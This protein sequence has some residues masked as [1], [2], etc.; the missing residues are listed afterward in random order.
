M[1]EINPLTK[2]EVMED[3]FIGMLI[4]NDNKIDWA[5]ARTTQEQIVDEA[6]AALGELTSDVID[7]VGVL[8]DVKATKWWQFSEPNGFV[9]RL[10]ISKPSK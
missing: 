8:N 4:C 1:L 3:I 6:I 7:R 5:G 9:W 10:F 2:G